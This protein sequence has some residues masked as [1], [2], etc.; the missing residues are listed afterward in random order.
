[1]KA[2]KSLILIFVLAVLAAV[3]LF[4][5]VDFKIRIT[6]I[7]FGIGVLAFLG[8]VLYSLITNIKGNS[9]GLIGIGALVGMIILFYFIAPTGDID[10][11]RFEKTGTSL[12]WDPIIG[13]GLYTIYALLAIFV[14]ASIGLSIR[15][16]LK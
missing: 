1:M 3:I 7:V 8:Y 15:N 4:A 14:I 10:A 12:S 6:Y 13:A 16:L 11:A 9:K 5:G 2:L